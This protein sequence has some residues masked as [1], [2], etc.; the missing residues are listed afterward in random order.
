M[1]GATVFIER[2]R[3]RYTAQALQ[4]FEDE[5]EDTLKRKGALDAEVKAAVEKVKATFRRKLQELATDAMDTMIPMDIRPNAYADELTE[6]LR[7]DRDAN[8]QGAATT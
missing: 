4:I 6:Q 1:A 5:L 7:P 3:A 8:H 2:R